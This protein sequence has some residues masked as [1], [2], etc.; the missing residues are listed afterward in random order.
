MVAAAPGRPLAPFDN[1]LPQG[2]IPRVKRLALPITLFVFACDSGLTPTGGPADG[3]SDSNLG[4][5]AQ[6]RADAYGNCLDTCVG[7]QTCPEDSACNALVGLCIPYSNQPCDPLACREGWACSDDDPFAPCAPTAGYCD[8]DRDCPFG[9]RCDDNGRC[10]SRAS[11]IVET[12]D[13]DSDCNRL[14]TG[15]QCRLGVCTGCIDDLQCLPLDPGAECVLGTCVVADV[16]PVAQCLLN[17]C[18]EG[19]RCNLTN[20]QCEPA[21]DTDEDCAELEICAPVLDRCVADPSCVEDVDCPEGLTCRGGIFGLDGVCTGCND[22]TP[23]GEGLRCIIGTCL[24]RTGGD[25]LC[26]DVECGE[27]QLC[28]PVDGS[29]YLANGTCDLD[30]DCRDGFTCNLVGFCAGCSDSI[31]CRPEQRCI[32]GTCAPF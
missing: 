28:D 2:Q 26:D 22:E 17:R 32:F 23:C 16:G 30:E 10:G 11:D 29:C 7:E 18:D 8:R 9:Q 1:V 13:S 25:G 3:D 31:A 20:G 4:C 24:P 5:P 15:M 27:D 19:L 21:C 12:C 14:I 6:Q